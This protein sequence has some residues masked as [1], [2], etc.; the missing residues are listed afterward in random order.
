MRMGNYEKVLILVPS[1][2]RIR[3]RK[4]SSRYAHKNVTINLAGYQI[5]EDT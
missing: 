1:R 3:G 2:L 5:Y 4:L